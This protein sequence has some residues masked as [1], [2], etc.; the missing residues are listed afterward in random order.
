MDCSIFKIL[1][2]TSQRILC[3]SISLYKIEHFYYKM[4]EKSERIC[5][6]KCVLRILVCIY[7]CIEAIQA[8]VNSFIFNYLEIQKY[9]NRIKA[10][11]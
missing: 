11:F 8:S 5:Y 6:V 7:F 4:L 2:K 10:Y 3:I 1:K 9:W